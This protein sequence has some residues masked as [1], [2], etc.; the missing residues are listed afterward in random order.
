MD[1]CRPRRSRDYAGEDADAA[2]RLADDAGTA[3]WRSTRLRKLYDELEVPLIDVLA[4]ME[5]TGIRLDV[6][7]LDK[8]GGEMATQLD[9]IEKDDPRARRPA[10]QHRAR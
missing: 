10:V 3:N 7:F 8:L 4:E 1:R 2:W 6:P 5:Y 9:G